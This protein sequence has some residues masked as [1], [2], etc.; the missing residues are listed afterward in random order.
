MRSAVNS[1]ESAIQTYHQRDT[2]KT[3]ER[4]AD[5]KAQ[6]KNMGSFTQLLSSELHARDA[7]LA[8]Y[9]FNSDTKSTVKK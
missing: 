5:L 2:E 9:F 1:L 8:T 4:Q 6:C 3:G 7:D